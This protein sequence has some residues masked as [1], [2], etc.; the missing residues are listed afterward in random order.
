MW[1]MATM[2]GKHGLLTVLKEIMLYQSPENEQK[3][4]EDCTGKTCRL[5]MQFLI[6]FSSFS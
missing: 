1:K 6:G 4:V 5:P 2:E 3:K